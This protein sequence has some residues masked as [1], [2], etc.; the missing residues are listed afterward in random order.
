MYAPRFAPEIQTEDISRDEAGAD[1]PFRNGML[2]VTL[3]DR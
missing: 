3:P 1:S 2:I